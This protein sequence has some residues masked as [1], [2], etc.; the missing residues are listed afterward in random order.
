MA[1]LRAV[2]AATSTVPGA[3]LFAGLKFAPVVPELSDGAYLVRDFTQG[4][5]SLPALA[6]TPYRFDVGRYN[7]R[8]R[9][10][11][12]SDLFG[13]ADPWAYQGGGDGDDGA[14]DVDEDEEAVTATAP[15]RDIHIG[16]DIGGPVG[17]AVHAFADGVVHSAGYNAAKLDYGHVV[18]TEHELNG[19]RVWALFGHLSAQSTASK[20]RGDPVRQGEALGWLGDSHEN[21]GWPS[22][23]HV[24][25]SL[26]EPATHDM[27]GVVSSGKQYEQALR[28]YIDPR[29]VLGPLYTG[30]G[31]FE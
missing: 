11:Y 30:D 27:P 19:I 9:A 28:D 26:V 2:G 18:V 14:G 10:M 31:L 1:V 21:G 4:M 8:R 29:M 12:T 3:G 17:T 24:Q 20:R 5:S 25:L 16:L 6:D 13:N 22:H 23:V 7:E 15:P